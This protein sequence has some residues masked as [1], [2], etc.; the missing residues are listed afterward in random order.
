MIIFSSWHLLED[1][2][3]N[4][5][6]KV[7]VL[8]AKNGTAYPQTSQGA[9]ADPCP[10]LKAP[11][12]DRPELDQ[13]AMEESGLSDESHCV[14]YLRDTSHKNAQWEEGKPVETV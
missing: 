8:E 5:V 12:I 3:E 2:I 11:T 13:E 6:L 7:Y 4:F 1:S 14:T 9:H 10:V